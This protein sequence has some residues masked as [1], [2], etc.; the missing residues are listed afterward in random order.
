MGRMLKDFSKDLDNFL[1][2]CTASQ[3]AFTT[4][5]PKG[6]NP[7]IRI[8]LLS[9][10]MLQIHFICS[11]KR[12]FHVILTCLSTFCASA[13]A[14]SLHWKEREG[15]WRPFLLSAGYQQTADTCQVWIRMVPWLVRFFHQI[16]EMWCCC[17]NNELDEE[18]P[19]FDGYRI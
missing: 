15:M 3:L 1:S 6:P 9:S 10:A 17:L 13:S 2:S 7:V 8:V 19:E 4:W 5:F 18:K 12:A 11:H 16:T 14:W